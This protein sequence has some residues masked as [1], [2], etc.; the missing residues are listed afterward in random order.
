MVRTGATFEDACAEYLHWLEEVRQRKPST[1]RDY[2]GIIRVHLIPFFT[3]VPVEDITPEDA[4]AWAAQLGAGRRMN[5]RT[6]IKVMTVLYGVMERARKVH[7]LPRNPM[8]AVE[9]PIQRVSGDIDVF[10]VEEVMAL[11]RAADD[12]QDAA[13]YL[14]AALTGLRRGELVALRWRDV[15]FAGQSIRVRASYTEGG[16]T[17]P[18]SGKV[19]AVPMA[20][21]V[22]SALA[23]LAA[24][25][26]YTAN[27]DL[28]FPGVGAVPTLQACAGERGPAPAALPRPAPHVRNPHDRDRVDPAGQ[29]L[30]GSRRR[31][32][33]DEVPALRAAC[34][35]G[36]AR[37]RGVRIGGAG[38]RSRA[39]VGGWSRRG[40]A[41]APPA[42]SG[43]RRE[44]LQHRPREA[45]VAAQ[46]EARQ[47]A[48][49]NGLV[50]PAGP[51]RQQLRGLLGLEQR[52]GEGR[53]AWVGVQ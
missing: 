17:T 37:R 22:S 44:P 53:W 34:G 24:R 23:R 21:Q 31:R 43:P 11:V 36:A 46:L 49:A 29:G 10:S 6:K 1:L 4:D 32:D 35:G 2:R 40:R 16:L 30:D 8:A 42:V 33:D 20:P 39:G 51:D 41:I 27:D 7:K 19:R 25:E 14:T 47:R 9:K 15:D 52:L 28:V 48:R 12:E 38:R 26:A 13:I 5:N 50:D 45:D 18:K 3:G